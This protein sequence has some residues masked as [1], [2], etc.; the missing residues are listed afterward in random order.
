MCWIC[1]GVCFRGFISPP[2]H[3]CP[4]R[5]PPFSIKLHNNRKISI[6]ISMKKKSK[7]TNFS[8]FFY[9]N[10]SPFFR[11]PFNAA[12][13]GS[14]KIP[15]E[16]LSTFRSNQ[17]LTS[18]PTLAQPFSNRKER[19]QTLPLEETNKNKHNV[20]AILA[21]QLHTV[22]KLVPFLSGLQ[23]CEAR[24]RTAPFQSRVRRKLSVSKFWD[25]SGSSGNI[26]SFPTGPR[27]PSIVSGKRKSAA[28][29]SCQ[30]KKKN[31]PT[32]QW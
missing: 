32:F 1:P 25:F 16:T 3:E 13:F 23:G 6:S 10:F 5:S 15:T 30:L 22:R 24:L 26:G 19:V 21:F 29:V 4:I 31:L 7:E 18:S 8:H 9:D 27:I 20:E 2:T 14:K 28:S 11:S 17:I 12:Q